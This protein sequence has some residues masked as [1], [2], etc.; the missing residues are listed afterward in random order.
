MRIATIFSCFALFTVLACK[1]QGPTKP[2][3]IPASSNQDI[4]AATAYDATRPVAAERAPNTAPIVTPDTVNVVTDDTP[5]PRVIQPVDS[6]SSGTIPGVLPSNGGYG[7]AAPVAP[8]QIVPGAP[9]NA[10]ATSNDPCNRVPACYSQM[11]RELCTGGRGDCLAELQP[12]AVGDDLSACKSALA[13]AADAARAFMTP[14]YRVPD[15]CK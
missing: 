14:G 10:S 2:T 13:G 3:G 6:G 1:E 11:Q 15:A 9:R 12:P 8:Q 5:K 7:S 4:A